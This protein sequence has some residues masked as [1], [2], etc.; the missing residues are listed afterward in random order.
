MMKQRPHP[1]CIASSK[2]IMSCSTDCSKMRSCDIHQNR[3][4]NE[5]VN[6]E[7]LNC[8]ILQY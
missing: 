5:L 4:V 8:A 7:Q 3:T 1:V 6:T 2:P